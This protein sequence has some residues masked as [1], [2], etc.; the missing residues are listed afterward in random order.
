MRLARVR[1][2]VRRTMIAVAVVA[3]VIGGEK[4]RRRAVYCA[5][6]AR[7][8]DEFAADNREWLRQAE[9]LMAPGVLERSQPGLDAVSYRDQ[10]RVMARDITDAKR[11]S[12]E[13]PSL[14]ARWRRA[15]RRPWRSVPADLTRH[16]ELPVCLWGWTQADLDRVTG[17]PAPD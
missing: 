15:A 2:T 9:L 13:A 12:A 11:W 7:Y 5:G 4:M 17:G 6:R 1:F 16:P 8:F 3:A 10:R 14:A